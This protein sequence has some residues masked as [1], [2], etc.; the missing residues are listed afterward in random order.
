MED[1]V[2]L[3]V[4]TEYSLL[5]G[6]SKISQLLDRAI[7]LNQ[8]AI[9]ITDH[10]VMYGAVE[11]YKKA[12]AKGIKPII[13]CEVYVAPRTRFDKIHKIDSSPYHLVLL[14]KNEV[15]YKNLIKLVS[16]GFIEGFYSK[17]RVDIELLKKHS[18]GLIALSG[19]LAGQIPRLLSVGDYGQAV[20]VAKEYK[21]IFG[22]DNYYI[23]IQN[24]GIKE[25]INILPDLVR[26]SEETKVGLVATNDCHYIYQ[27]DSKIQ[28]ILICI[29]TNKTV[30][31]PNNM[32]FQTDEFY[33]KSEDEMSLLFGQYKNA[34]SNTSKIADMCN[35]EF[36]FGV[37]KLPYY[38]APNG[39]DNDDYFE[40][41]CYKGLF[42]KY[43]NNPSQD[44]KDRLEYEMNI[45]KTMGYVNYYLIV[46]D[47]INY[48]RT[49]NIPVGPGRGSG[50]GSLAAY[51]I[52]ITGIDPIKYNLLFERFLNPERISMPDFDID[53]CYERRQEVIDYVVEKYGKDHVAQIITFGTMAAKGAIRDVGRALGLSYQFVDVIAKLI[54][55]ELNITIN[56]ALND[57][58]E[59]KEQYDKSPQVKQLIDTAIKL[60]GM[61]KHSSTHA[62]GVVIT[63]DTVESYVP[64][65]S[66][67]GAIVTQYT[68]TTL[69]ELGLLKMDFLGL[70]NLTVIEETSNFVRKNKPDFDISKI[71]LCD[72]KVFKMLASGKTFGVFQFESAGMRQVLVQIKPNCVEDLIAVISLYRPGPMDSIPTYIK[73]RNNPQNIKYKTN[74]LKPILDVTCGCIIYQEQVMQI[75]RELAGYS[76]GR[77]DLVRRAMSKKKI[78][79][80]EGER[81]SFIYGDN[82]E[83]STSKCVGC[84]ANG[85]SPEIAN[86]I[87][88]EMSSFASYAFN[89]SHAAAY[90][91]LSYQTAY[92][93]C[94]YTTAYMAALL[95]SVIDNTDKIIEYINE[96]KRL[97]IEILPPDVNKSELNFTVENDKIRFGLFAIKN[98]GKGVILNLI[99]ERKNGKF[100]DYPQFLERLYGKNISK[101][102]VESLIKC[103]SMDNLG[104]NRNEMMSSFE[105]ILADVD[106]IK[107]QN[108]DGQ[109]N[110]FSNDSNTAS[111]KIVRKEE[112]PQFRLLSMEKEIIGLYVSGHPLEKYEYLF[113][114]YKIATISDILHNVKDI[115]N[116]N[117]DGT[118]V[119]VIGIVNAVKTKSTKN[120]DT[121]AF[122]EL[123]DMTSTIETLLFPTKYALYKDILSSINPIVIEGKI[124][125]REEKEPTIICSAIYD[126]S[127][128]DLINATMKNNNNFNA[129]TYKSNTTNPSS[130]INNSSTKKG[131]YLKVENAHSSEM[132]KIKSLLEFFNEDE[133]VNYPVYVYFNEDKK[134]T[135]APK[136]LWVRLCEPLVNEARYILGDKN[137][138]VR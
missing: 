130:E 84:V 41:L 65:Q 111:Y 124:S 100:T 70:R 119:T 22:E 26:L 30:S 6:A 98:L 57:C 15:G 75:F 105:M 102:T 127:N 85:I 16:A 76:Y 9:A 35:I 109:T 20:S 59:L 38:S 89:K 121:M 25:Q 50:A 39:Q 31:E 83:K 107:C 131:L 7:E 29:Q 67:D 36:E 116:K 134:L 92:L 132:E 34:I 129:N 44:I 43:D 45:I 115:N 24:H 37:T 54:P 14:C 91:T 19:C 118:F 47:F 62:A 112:Y 79:V 106:S 78:D 90:A 103:G 18:E 13:G 32:E 17:P 80:M 95:T 49:Q 42:E 135:V 138:A 73:N 8:K 46:Y 97:K 72:E 110:L 48:A 33:V 51:C 55:S 113:K 21:S 60:E 87:F 99:E 5:D 114:K 123:E 126:I 82:E 71:N 52:G 64:L 77:A 122:A 28:N 2:H 101:R 93:K 136:G 1:F 12:K 74:L 58:G 53:F 96:C 117:Y 66:N 10:G 128:Y 61:P 104:Y 69:E 27:E 11:F 63:K 4:H 137:V 40:K 108:I 86:S 81:K 56:K 23:E 68:M 3:H 120:N 88:D 125:I 133:M 94:H